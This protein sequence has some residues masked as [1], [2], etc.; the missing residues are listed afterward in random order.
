ML[1]GIHGFGAAGRRHASREKNIR[2]NPDTS[3]VSDF[4]WQQI[5]E[6]EIAGKG[7]AQVELKIFFVVIEAGIIHE[8]ELIEVFI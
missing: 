7:Y 1:Q 4:L 5:V 2:W 3:W 8:V 6:R